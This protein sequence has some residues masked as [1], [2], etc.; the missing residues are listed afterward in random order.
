MNSRSQHARRS[1]SFV[2]L[3]LSSSAEGV[4]QCSPAL[5]Q[6]VFAYGPL[7]EK[8]SRV[9]PRCVLT[10]S[11]D[12]ALPPLGF[13]GLCRGTPKAQAR[14]TFSPADFTYNGAHGGHWTA[15]VRKDR[16]RVHA[17]YGNSKIARALVGVGVTMEELHVFFASQS[18][19]VAGVPLML[20]IP[21]SRQRKGATPDVKMLGFVCSVSADLCRG[22]AK[23]GAVKRANF[24]VDRDFRQ[25]VVGRGFCLGDGLLASKFDAAGIGASACARSCAQRIFQNT[26]D[27]RLPSC[28]GFA[29]SD[30]ARNATSCMLYRGWP[31]KLSD[32][33]TAGYTCVSMHERRDLKRLGVTN[34]GDAT[35]ADR[36]GQEEILFE[37]Y[38]NDAS[39]AQDHRF[40]ATILDLG[41]AFASLEEL[42][43]TGTRTLVQFE[44]GNC[45][46]SFERIALDDR[47]IYIPPSH[48]HAL[49]QI[50]STGNGSSDLHGLSASSTSSTLSNQSSTTD[51]GNWQFDISVERVCV[52]GCLAGVASAELAGACASHD[53]AGFSTAYVEVA[54]DR[55]SLVHSTQRAPGVLLQEVTTLTVEDVTSSVDFM[56]WYGYVMLTIT[57]LGC[58]FFIVLGSICAATGREDANSAFHSLNSVRLDHEDD[59]AD[60]ASTGL[61]TVVSKGY[62]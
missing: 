13:P 8:I 52:R 51:V 49:A 60:G 54:A 28:T 9:P 2:L 57:L 62:N 35:L 37:K 41:T 34:V 58:C 22:L 19:D 47:A 3:P 12:D 16:A 36:E 18:S 20:T 48:H 5:S 1:V 17:L 45:S 33:S 42:P 50:L 39:Q 24:V 11:L 10:P 14:A 53:A 40:P 21:L 27:A 6:H 15:L 32:G 4:A 29:W 61:L 38:V 30:A 56:A 25:E 44:Y 7:W 55:S 31:V 46:T 23:E 26:R 43:L 59:D